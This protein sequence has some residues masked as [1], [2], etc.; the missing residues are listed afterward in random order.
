MS[1]PQPITSEALH[2]ARLAH[3][4]PDEDRDPADAEREEQHQRHP[5]D[6]LPSVGVDAE[7]DEVAEADHETRAD[8]E[9]HE[10]AEHRADERR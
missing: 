8:D 7:A 1:E 6:R 10:L 4:H 5:G 3:H 2:R 9:A